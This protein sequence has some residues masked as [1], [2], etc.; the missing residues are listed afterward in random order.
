[1]KKSALASTV[2]IH[3]TAIVEPGAR[4]G[5]LTR[6]W[7]HAHVR[8][9]ARIG[10]ACSLGKNVYIDADAVLGD[11]CHVQN[12]CSIYSGVILGASVFVGPHVTFT[13]DKHP[14]VSDHWLK[15]GTQVG[16]HVSF[17]AH[18]TIVC[19]IT[20]GEYAMI[21]AGAVVT[22][23]VPAH[24]LVAGNPAR[25]IGFVCKRGHTMERTSYGWRCKDCNARVTLAITYQE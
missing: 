15:V 9:A 11:G 20:I 3:P 10:R 2:I 12:N 13:N 23:D 4:V 6:I 16:D 21:A 24:A 22:H 14:R 1:M 19:G 17:G 25:L 18:S 5:A 8:N 7:H